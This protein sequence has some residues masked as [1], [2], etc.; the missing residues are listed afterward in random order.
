MLLFYRCDDRKSV[1]VLGSVVDVKRL[2]DSDKIESMVRGRT[3]YD[4]SEI[5]QMLDNHKGPLLIICFDLL[6]Y[7]S[8]SV[9]LSRLKEIGVSTV[10]VL[11]RISDDQFEVIVKEGK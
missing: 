1:E 9:P 5:E 7:F 3:V 10:R 4:P 11:H 6:D 8:E 2:G